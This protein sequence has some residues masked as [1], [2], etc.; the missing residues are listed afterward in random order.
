MENLPSKHHFKNPRPNPRR[1]PIPEAEAVAALLGL[2][3]DFEGAGVVVGAAGVDGQE[4]EIGLAVE[5]DRKSV[6]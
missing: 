3:G 2:A 4:A 5:L 6:V 1:L